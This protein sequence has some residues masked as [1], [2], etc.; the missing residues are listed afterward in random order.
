MNNRHI[1]S[2]FD[3]FLEEEGLL[4]E[5]EQAVKTRKETSMTIDQILQL[6]ASVIV[7]ILTT[8]HLTQEDIAAAQKLEEE[9]R[10]HG[11]NVPDYVGAIAGANPKR[12]HDG[13]VLGL[14][15]ELLLDSTSP[16]SDSKEN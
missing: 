5:I 10:N 2:N 1:G 7:T 12:L 14:A 11:L 3:D 13:Y 15:K 8:D 9:L 6:H 16:S 4:R